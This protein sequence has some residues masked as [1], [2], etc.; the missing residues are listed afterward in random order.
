[1]DL[2][3]LALIG[4]LLL[5]AGEK[6]LADYVAS[7]MLGDSS[8]DDDYVPPTKTTIKKKSAK[9]KKVK[10]QAIA[11]ESEEEIYDY[12]EEEGDAVPEEDLEVNVDENGFS[13]LA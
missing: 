7:L 3:K 10:R 12:S 2:E 4:D 9:G 11:D 1:M 8:E 13:S 5:N 6:D